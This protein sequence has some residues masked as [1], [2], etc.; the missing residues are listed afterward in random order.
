ME[1]LVFFVFAGE[2]GELPGLT[3]SSLD[4]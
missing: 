3:V 1:D 2:A 4:S